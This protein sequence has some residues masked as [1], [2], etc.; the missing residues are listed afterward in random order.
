VII[1]KNF[2]VIVRRN[3]SALSLK[4]CMKP[5]HVHKYVLIRQGANK[6]PIY[7]CNL[8]GCPHYIEVKLVNGRICLCNRCDTEFV[9]RFN[10]SR[11]PKKPHCDNCTRSKV[12]VVS[13]VVK[14][15]SGEGHL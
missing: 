7:K 3:T 14:F 6:H 15:L 10:T 1:R 2:A 4:G 11:P 5:K 9:F 12:D 13:K 8:D